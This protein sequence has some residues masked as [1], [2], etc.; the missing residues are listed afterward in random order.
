MGVLSGSLI[1]HQ[2]VE[3]S[4]AFPHLT[5]ERLGD[6]LVVLKHLEGRALPRKGQTSSV[7]HPGRSKHL[8]PTPVYHCSRQ[9]LS[10]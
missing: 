2:L 7:L 1:L 8:R 4:V 5:D 9:D 6:S 3:I 10:R